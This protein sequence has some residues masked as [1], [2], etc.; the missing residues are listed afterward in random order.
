MLQT[1]I[2]HCWHRGD[3]VEASNIWTYVMLDST[4]DEL[5]NLKN[6]LLY[7]LE[8]SAIKSLQAGNYGAAK[9]CYKTALEIEPG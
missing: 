8:G 4:T 3:E 6:Q 9:Q 1:E 5:E 7:I 2:T